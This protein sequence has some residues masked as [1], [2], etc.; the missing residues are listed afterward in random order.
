MLL[1][2]RDKLRL[3]RKQAVGRRGGRGKRRDQVV[4]TSEDA[5][6]PTRRPDAAGPLDPPLKSEPEQQKVQQQQ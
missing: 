4:A 3:L 1:A 2:E 6:T 5:P